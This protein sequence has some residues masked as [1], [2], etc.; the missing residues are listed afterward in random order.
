MDDYHCVLR[1]NNGNVV[2][3]KSAA[4]KVLDGG[5]YSDYNGVLVM[6][7]YIWRLQW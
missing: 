2:K 3:K 4:V 1:I 7:V 5:D 6:H